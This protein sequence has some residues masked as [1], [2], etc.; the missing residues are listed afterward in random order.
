MSRGKFS[1]RKRIKLVSL[2]YGPMTGA[3][4]GKFSRT[5]RTLVANEPCCQKNS[6]AICCATGSGPIATIGPIVGPADHSRGTGKRGLPRDLHGPLMAPGP[7]EFPP[8]FRLRNRER[9]PTAPYRARYVDRGA[10]NH[11]AAA[12]RIRPAAA[13][14]PA[15]RNSNINRAVGC[16]APCCGLP[17]RT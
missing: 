4:A 2:D 14:R 3:I 1:R 8:S 6:G 11:I 5:K 16:R 12:A 10:R 17:R 9:Y 13:S 15:A 7:L